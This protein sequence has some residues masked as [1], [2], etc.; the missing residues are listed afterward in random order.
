MRLLAELHDL[1]EVL[2]VDVRV[3]AEQPLQDR[4]G[5]RQEALGERHTCR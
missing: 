4:L 1:R 2:V 3:H 5:A